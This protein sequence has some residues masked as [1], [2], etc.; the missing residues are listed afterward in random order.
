MKI[1]NNTAIVINTTTT[2]PESV[3]RIASA[4]I[5]IRIT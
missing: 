1:L 2:N 3:T 5:L 4:P